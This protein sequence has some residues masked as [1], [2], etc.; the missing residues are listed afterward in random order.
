MHFWSS[1]LGLQI[2]IWT[3]SANQNYLKVDQNSN[4]TRDHKF[5]GE[6]KWTKTTFSKQIHPVILNFLDAFL[7]RKLI[8]KNLT[9]NWTRKLDWYLSLTFEPTT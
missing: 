1:D 9:Q 8:P 7:D 2:R 6:I 5:R 3:K 4:L